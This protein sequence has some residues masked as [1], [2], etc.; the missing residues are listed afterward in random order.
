MLKQ[1]DELSKLRHSA[2]HVMA[3]AVKHL[4]P[5]AKVTIGPPTADGFYYDFDVARPFT[6]EDL[7][8]I[9]AFKR[10]SVAGAY[11]R[12]SEKNPMLQRI[13]G[14]AFFTQAEL[15]DFMHRLAEAEKR[16]HRKLGREL[17]LFSISEDVGPGLIL[18]HPKGGRLRTVVEDF[19]RKAHYDRGYD[20]VCTPHIGRAQLWKT[21][22][23]LDFY[24]ENMYAPVEV[25][26]QQYFLK[27]MNCPFHIQIFRTR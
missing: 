9:K 5:D 8:S 6:P 19:W 25:D 18:W 15:D 22:G 23:H 21:S 14:T 1:D 2:A 10:L 3:Q 12:G 27:P 24:A 13:Y 7:E 11:W 4:F 16:D 20:L 26:G 17:D